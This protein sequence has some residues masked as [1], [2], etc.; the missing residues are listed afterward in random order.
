MQENSFYLLNFL[1]F[2]FF[3]VFLPDFEGFV[4]VFIA[5]HFSRITLPYLP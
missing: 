4:V 5:L 1:S 2:S 3:D